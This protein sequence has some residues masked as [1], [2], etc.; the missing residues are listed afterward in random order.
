MGILASLVTGT[1]HIRQV[2]DKITSTLC[3]PVVAT[4]NM[5]SLFP[6][7]GNL[8]T[9]ILERSIDCAFLCEIWEQS[10]KKEHQM[11]I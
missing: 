4:Y 7:L 3:M 8:K 11:Q 6:Q 5:R 10:A 2:K 9:D 1:I